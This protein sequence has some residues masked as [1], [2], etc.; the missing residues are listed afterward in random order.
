MMEYIKYGQSREIGAHLVKKCLTAMERNLAILEHMI[1]HG[2]ARMKTCQRLS[3]HR[4]HPTLELMVN[5][6][7]NTIFLP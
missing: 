3:N 5:G 2:F 7:K 6:S 1:A 4:L